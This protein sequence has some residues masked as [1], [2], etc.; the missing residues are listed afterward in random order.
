V[1]KALDEVAMAKSA[2]PAQVALAWLMARP[3]ISAPIASATSLDQLND[4]L[5]A[6]KLDLSRADI[7]ALDQASA[8]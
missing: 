5:G 7:A 1:L 8:Y 3:G 6:A 2:T 4:I